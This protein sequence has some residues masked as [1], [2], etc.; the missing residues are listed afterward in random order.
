MT[1]DNKQQT[2]CRRRSE[3]TALTQ[4]ASESILTETA[5]LESS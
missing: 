1:N 4:A 3:E 2:T 5:L